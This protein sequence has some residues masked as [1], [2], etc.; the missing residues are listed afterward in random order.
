MDTF[1]VL[2]IGLSMLLG[3]ALASAFKGFA[4]SIRWQLLSTRSLPLED[5]DR[6]MQCES[7]LATTQLLWKGRVK[8]R[9]MPSRIQWY[10][11]VALS[12]N[13]GLQVVVASLGLYAAPKISDEWMTLTS[14]YELARH[15]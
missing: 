3:M 7:L 9:L 8:G 4:Q 15:S 13:L 5:F 14:K 10:C 11:A 2:N 12:L 6:V 1:N